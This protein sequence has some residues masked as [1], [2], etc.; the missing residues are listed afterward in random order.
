[1]ATK[2]KKKV[3]KNG[4]AFTPL[5]MARPLNEDLFFAASLNRIEHCIKITI[6]IFYR[7]VVFKHLYNQTL[8]QQTKINLKI[9]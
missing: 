1:M 2:F 9:Y 8:Y 3:T 7:A 6:C 4:R 5:L